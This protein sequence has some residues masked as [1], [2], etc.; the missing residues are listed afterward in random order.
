MRKTR[1]KRIKTSRFICGKCGKFTYSIPRV[2]NTREK[3]H[4]K[5]L[6]CPWCKI[7]NN[8]IEIRDCDFFKTMNGEYI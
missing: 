1:P 4:V 8:C 5:Y 7:K 3:G 6:Y 2:K